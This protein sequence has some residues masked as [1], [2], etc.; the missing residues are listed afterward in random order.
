MLWREKGGP[1]DALRAVEGEEAVVDLAGDL[2]GA[3][4][5]EEKPLL[6]QTLEVGV[7][8]GERVLPNTISRSP[9]GNRGRETHGTEIVGLVDRHEEVL[10]DKHKRGRG[11]E[12]GVGE[13]VCRQRGKHT[14]GAS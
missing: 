7:E 1:G 10:D 4:E 5:V 8:D 11:H 6:P 14:R 3:E 9:G 2:F 13:V 12:H